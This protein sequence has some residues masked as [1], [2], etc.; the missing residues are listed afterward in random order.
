MKL[1]LNNHWTARSAARVSCACVLGIAGLTAP[2]LHAQEVTGS[3]GWQFAATIYGWLPDIG[4]HT[5]L[6]LGGGNTINVDVSTILDHLKMTGMGSFEFSKG[7]WGAFTDLIYLDVG[8]SNSRVRNLSIG[9][10]PLP[11]SVTASADFD[12]KSTIWSLAA[13]YLVV[14]GAETTFD[15]LGGARLAHMKETLDWTFTDNFGPITPPPITGSQDT[16]VD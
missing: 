10:V 5:E 13:T 6:P 4:G 7:R 11:A 12:L 8:D 14:G 9:G 16:S 2:P 3:S 15:V 1:V